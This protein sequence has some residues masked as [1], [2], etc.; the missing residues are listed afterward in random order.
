MENFKIYIDFRI[1]IHPHLSRLC[2]KFIALQIQ[3]RGEKREGLHL[4]HLLYM[5]KVICIILC[6]FCLIYAIAITACCL[7][8]FYKGCPKLL[9]VE[10]TTNLS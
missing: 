6:L 10:K 1:E 8:S 3:H 5:K 2:S 7:Y 4:W 9:N